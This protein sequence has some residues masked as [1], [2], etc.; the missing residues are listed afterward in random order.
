MKRT[1]L[2]AA[3]A[4]AVAPITVNAQ[5]CA[6]DTDHD[7]PAC[8]QKIEGTQIA[9]YGIGGAALACLAGYLLLRRRQTT[10]S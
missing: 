7:N 8:P 2:L 6:Q 4:L 10:N 1:L 9:R 5:N 3:L